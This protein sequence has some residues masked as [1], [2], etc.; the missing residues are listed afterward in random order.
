MSS[1]YPRFASNYQKMEIV[2][3]ALSEAVDYSTY[4][5]LVERLFA[6]GKSTGPKQS[7]SLLKY[8]ELNLV[9]MNRLAKTIKLEEAV[10]KKLQE[11]SRP[12]LWLTLTEGW[13]GDAANISPYIEK[14]AEVNPL[15]QTQYVLRDEHPELMDLF[16]TNGSRSIPMVIVID[17]EKKAFV[18]NW[19]PRPTEVQKMVEDW[20][21]GGKNPPYSEFSVEVQKWYI[22]DRGKSL[23]REFLDFLTKEKQATE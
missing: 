9:R 15:I 4:K 3:K 10:V 22:K 17:P 11:I 20:I 23:Q 2:R 14:M 6:E 8:T 5:E 12:Q 1:L 18:G 21:A 16:L 7:E 13:C 19:G